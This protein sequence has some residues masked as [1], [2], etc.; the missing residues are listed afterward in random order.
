[1]CLQE[2]TLRILYPFSGHRWSQ[3]LDARAPGNFINGVGS[4]AKDLGERKLALQHLVLAFI[5]A[6]AASTMR[7]S[8]RTAKKPTLSDSPIPCAQCGSLLQK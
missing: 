4:D 5:Q 1:M 7:L 6:A 2:Q 3:R 8:G